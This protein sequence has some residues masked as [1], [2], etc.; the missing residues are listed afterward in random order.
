M[1]RVF[2]PWWK[3]DIDECAQ[4]FVRVFSAEPWSEPWTLETAVE[5]L[6]EIQCTPGFIG[7]V[8]RRREVLAFAAGYSETSYSGRVFYLQEMCVRPELQRQGVGGELQRFLECQLVGENIKH[9]YLLT[10]AES[11]AAAFYAQSGYRASL[12]TQL[13]SKNL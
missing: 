9:A 8:C 1:K 3:G 12:R 6:R 13:M 10:R 5:R 2:E 4:V 7:V 11:T